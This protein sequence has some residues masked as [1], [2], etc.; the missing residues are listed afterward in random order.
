MERATGFHHRKVH[1]GRVRTAAGIRKYES[2]LSTSSEN[3]TLSRRNRLP[4]RTC[5]GNIRENQFCHSCTGYRFYRSRLNV[6][7]GTGGTS[8]R[9]TYR[10]QGTVE[11]RFAHLAKQKEIAGKEESAA[12]VLGGEPLLAG[13][14]PSTKSLKKGKLPPKNK[15]RLPRRQKKAQ[16]KAAG[17]L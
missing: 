10:L 12:T 5:Y 13:A 8:H 1:L 14:K 11:W 15:F 16:Q 4:A 17:R 6:W 3:E 7:G 9:T 2:S